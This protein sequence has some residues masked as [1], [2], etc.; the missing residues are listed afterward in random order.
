M[1]AYRPENFASIDLMYGIFVAWFPF[2]LYA[3]W[4]Q[5]YGDLSHVKLYDAFWVF[6]VVAFFLLI[7]L[8][9]WT[10]VFLKRRTSSPHWRLFRV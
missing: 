2:Q 1:S 9:A 6:L 5:W 8:T 10:V 3:E 4:H 7:L